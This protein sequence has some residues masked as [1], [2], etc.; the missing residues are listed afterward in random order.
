MQKIIKILIELLTKLLKEEET[1]A[2]KQPLT[3]QKISETKMMLDFKN[4]SKKFDKFE[5][6]KLGEKEARFTVYKKN[7]EVFTEIV[8]DHGQQCIPLNLVQ[9]IAETQEFEIMKPRFFNAFII[10]Y[11]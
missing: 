8:V 10:W 11:W 9:L 2:E 1:Q 3:F 4:Q 7:G 5:I 6:E